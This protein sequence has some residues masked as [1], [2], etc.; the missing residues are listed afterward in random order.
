MRKTTVDTRRRRVLFGGV[1][2]I[3]SLPLASLMQGAQAEAADLPHLAQDDPTAK[4]LNYHQDA[5]AAPRSDQGGIPAG[6]QFCHNCKFIQA[7]AGTWRP[8]Q[9]FPGKAV[10]ANGWCSSWVRQ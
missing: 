8:C 10:N 2:A 6:Q 1:V 3:A 7:D 9:I 5:T 4:A